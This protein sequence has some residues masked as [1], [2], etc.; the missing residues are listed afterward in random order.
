MIGIGPFALGEVT[1]G[2]YLVEGTQ[3]DVV[4]QEVGIAHASDVLDV[5]RVNPRGVLSEVSL[6]GRFDE[7]VVEGQH[8]GALVEPV[9][10]V[11]IL[12]GVDAVM[13]VLC[14]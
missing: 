5:K 14:P 13:A 11:G 10:A 12:Q 4:G 1:V 8:L 3:T 2:D 6:E 7:V 9:V